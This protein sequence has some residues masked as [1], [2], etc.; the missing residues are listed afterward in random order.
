MK[1]IFLY[2]NKYNALYRSLAQ[3]LQFLCHTGVTNI[4]F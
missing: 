1:K 3:N 2:K 4:N